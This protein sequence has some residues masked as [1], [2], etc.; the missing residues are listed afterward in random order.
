ME[1]ARGPL[2][3]LYRCEPTCEIHKPPNKTYQRADP[4]PVLPLCVPATPFLQE[5][6]RSALLAADAPLVG[7]VPPRAVEEALRRGHRFFHQTAQAERQSRI[8]MAA[9]EAR[10]SLR[11]AQLERITYAVENVLG[12]REQRH[13]A[14]HARRCDIYRHVSQ[15]LHDLETRCGEKLLEGQR[16]DCELGE[17]LAVEREVEQTAREQ[18]RRIGVDGQDDLD[19][20]EEAVRR[21]EAEAGEPDDT[22]EAEDG[23]ESFF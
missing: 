19:R 2:G 13:E 11:A 23:D 20:I 8:A 22:A 7:G 3:G 9:T 16:L 21:L 17:L 6:V 14:A 10:I 15:H 18:A 1:A 12:Q 5:E 4:W